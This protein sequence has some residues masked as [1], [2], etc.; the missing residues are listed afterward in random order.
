MRIL[1]SDD[2]HAFTKIASDYLK[3]FR[4]EVVSNISVQTILDELM[5]HDEC[6]FD[7]IVMDVRQSLPGYMAQTGGL[8]AARI[9]RRLYH[10]RAIPIIFWSNMDL[11]EFEKDIKAISNSSFIPKIEPPAS[12]YGA[13]LGSCPKKET[14][15][16][17]DPMWFMQ[18]N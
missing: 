4:H 5:S 6:K 3:A 10:Y 15:L 7:A 17:I 16:R 11:K 12:L 18:S 1:I 9:I 8:E 2:N 14:E 13:I